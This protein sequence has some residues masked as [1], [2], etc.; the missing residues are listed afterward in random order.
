MDQ[1]GRF[2]SAQSRQHRVDRLKLNTAVGEP[3][4]DSGGVDRVIA[5]NGVFGDENFKAAF[6][7]F[8]GGSADAGMKVNPRENHRVAIEPPERGIKRWAGKRVEA[9]FVNDDFA[10]SRLQPGGG[11]VSAC[12][13]DAWPAIFCL[14]MR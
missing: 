14:P 4:A 8:G 13:G 2:I 3:A 6:K 12:A 10:R 5:A 11:F 9:G 1:L 7:A